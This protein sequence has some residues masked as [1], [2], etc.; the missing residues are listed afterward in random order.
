MR[1]PVPVYALMLASY[2][3]IGA[4]AVAAKVGHPS[5][6]SP[7][8]MPVLINGDYVFVANTPIKA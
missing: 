5:F 1:I 2:L 4:A 6:L 3:A 8:S 7:H